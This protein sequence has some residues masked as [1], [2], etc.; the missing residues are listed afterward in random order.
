MLTK[1]VLIVIMYPK[2]LTIFKQLYQQQQNNHDLCLKGKPLSL[3]T[4]WEQTK[5]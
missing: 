2:F 5:W 4:F 1:Y 3:A